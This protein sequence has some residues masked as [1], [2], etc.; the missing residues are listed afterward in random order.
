MGGPTKGRA[1][2]SLRLLP[3]ALVLAGLLTLASA[4]LAHAAP[5]PAHAAASTPAFADPRTPNCEAPPTPQVVVVGELTALTV[6][7]TSPS[8][9]PL[10]VT[11]LTGTITS[12]FGTLL[13]RAD[14]VGPG[15]DKITVRLAGLS[16]SG[17]SASFAVQ[18]VER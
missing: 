15:Y 13:Y 12:V 9:A 1:I 2:R 10:A 17:P 11:A 3:A 5:S 8:G 18:L 4:S 6:R 14:D 7:C 16:A